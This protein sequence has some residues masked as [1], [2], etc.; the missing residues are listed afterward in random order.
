MIEL[1]QVPVVGFH[2]T[3]LLGL[4]LWVY[5]EKVRKI[6]HPVIA[7][8]GRGG[9]L[10]LTIR[11][12]AIEDVLGQLQVLLAVCTQV[13]L[14]GEALD[15]QVLEAGLEEPLR[16]QEVGDN[17]DAILIARAEL[18][19]AHLVEAFAELAYGVRNY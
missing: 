5:A 4:L 15:V 11:H 2:V 1:E 3:R 13:E 16:E 19:P 17:A 9:N 14:L 12:Y 7:L 10:P 8:V 6:A 18:V